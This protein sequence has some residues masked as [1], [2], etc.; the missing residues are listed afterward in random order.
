M[1]FL[2]TGS[3]Q[4]PPTCCAGRGLSEGIEP[5]ARRVDKRSYP[6]GG[7][8]LQ[9]AF[10]EVLAEDVHGAVDVGVNQGAVRG[11]VQA[12]PDAASAE[13]MWKVAVEV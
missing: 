5:S 12:A 2:V 8:P 6:V 10:I 4:L 1:T 11:A 3:S 13:F 9:V 7:E